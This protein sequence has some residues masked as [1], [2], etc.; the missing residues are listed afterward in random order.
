MTSQSGCN[1]MKAELPLLCL[2]VALFQA[3]FGSAQQNK[4]RDCGERSCY[5]VLGVSVNAGDDDIKK[6]YR[7]VRTPAQLFDSTPPACARILSPRVVQ[8]HD[9]YFNGGAPQL[10]KQ[11]HPD[12]NPDKVEAAEQHFFEIGNAY[13]I[14]SSER[15]QCARTRPLFHPSTI[16]KLCPPP[17]RTHSQ[18][19]QHTRAC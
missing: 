7:A 19:L 11:W 15:E 18:K 8:L 6:A 2:V 17:A 9:L 16:V 14:L 1:R 5:D 12:K 3:Q 4:E 10:A 13:E